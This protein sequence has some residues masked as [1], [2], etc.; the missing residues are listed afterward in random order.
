MTTGQEDGRTIQNQMIK[1]EVIE[2]LQSAIDYRYSCLR[3]TARHEWESR[4]GGNDPSDACVSVRVT[5][6]ASNARVVSGSD[7]LS[8]HAGLIQKPK[9]FLP[10]FAH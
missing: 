1:Y 6:A 7:F 2:G 4:F 10:R 5:A 8:V 9:R 3:E